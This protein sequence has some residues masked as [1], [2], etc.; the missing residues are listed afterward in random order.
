M[1]TFNQFLE[2][3]ES[4]AG[5]RRTTSSS[6]MGSRLAPHGP[7]ANK[8]SRASQRHST[9]D[10]ISLRKAGFR[11]P[12]SDDYFPQ[13]HMS[14]SSTHHDTEV[15]TYKNQSDFARHNIPAKLKSVGRTEDGILKRRVIPTSE[16]V[17]FLKKLRDQLGGSR[18]KKPVHDV[19]ILS[20]G[21]HEHEKNDPKELVTRGKSFKKEIKSVPN[22][23][24]QSGGKPGDKVAG[25]PS[26]IQRIPDTLPPEEKTK[27]R[28]KGAKKRGKIY[29]RELG[30]SETNPTTGMNVGTLR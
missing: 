17:R 10:R 1:I 18:T 16:R 26:E 23:I 9:V 30:G 15:S 11:H 20:K 13:S 28:K 12:S 27:L 6:N 25:R 22:T 4:S 2:L 8:Y 21:E 24:K 14:S 3:A 5:R 19:S 7:K 29:H